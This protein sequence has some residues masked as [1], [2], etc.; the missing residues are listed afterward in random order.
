[1]N[2]KTIIF[3]GAHIDDYEWLGQQVNNN[4]TIICADS[5]LRHAHAIGITPDII[6]G[7]FDSVDSTL[8]QSY[9]GLS[10]IIKDDDQNTTDLMKALSQCDHS[11][12]VHIY[13]AVGARAD[14]DFSNYLILM[15]MEQTDNIAIITKTET[16]RV[17]KNSF[18]FHG[19]I[20]DY[21]GLFPLSPIQDLSV[22]GLKY[23]PSVLGGPYEFGW[24]GACN[25]MITDTASILFNKGCLLITHSQN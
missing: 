23:D 1:M 17:I 5:G 24:N 15:N 13:G 14:H 7:D 20:G 25:E 2:S 11:K 22:D 9:E 4:D 19:H 16:R 3:A 12:P 8:L 6:I 18:S 10:N 21:I